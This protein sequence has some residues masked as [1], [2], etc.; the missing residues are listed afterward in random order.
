MCLSVREDISGT[1]RAIFTKFFLCM[2]PVSAARSSSSTLTK[3]R[4]AYRR[5]G[6]TGSAQRGRS[7]IYTIILIVMSAIKPF[8]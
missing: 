6:V 8:N 1:T 7:V 3:G 4:I 5:E 2:M